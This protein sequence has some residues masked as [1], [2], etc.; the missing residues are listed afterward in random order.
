[1]V[2]ILIGSAAAGV[3]GGRS[4]EKCGG[5]LGGDRQPC[6]GFR[7]VGV[8]FAGNGHDSSA[9]M[10]AIGMGTDGGDAVREIMPGR[11]LRCM[12]RRTESLPDCMGTWRELAMRGESAIMIEAGG[13][14]MGFDGSLGGVWGERCGQDGLE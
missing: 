6:G 14:V 5:R 13:P 12:R 1:V 2:G 3:P 11:Y 4:K 7:R 8:G 9:P 10:A